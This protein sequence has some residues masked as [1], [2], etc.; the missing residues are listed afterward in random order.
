M[1]K[2]AAKKKPS[3]YLRMK[4]QMEK[5]SAVASSERKLTKN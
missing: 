2:Q 4:T 1:I 3:Y 5:E